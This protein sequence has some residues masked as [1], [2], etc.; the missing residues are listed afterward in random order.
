VLCFP[1]LSSARSRALGKGF[2]NLKIEFAEC[3]ITVGKHVFA[4]CVLTGTQQSLYL[5]S[6]PSAPR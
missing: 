4:E 5:A 6:L 2:F 3:Q 1:S